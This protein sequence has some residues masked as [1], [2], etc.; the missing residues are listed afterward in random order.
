MHA[1]A[2]NPGPPP[3]IGLLRRSWVR[4]ID[5]IKICLLC[6]TRCMGM[7]CGPGGEICYPSL[8]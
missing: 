8:Y 2:H 4:R 6:R 7:E 5:L 1:S 3:R